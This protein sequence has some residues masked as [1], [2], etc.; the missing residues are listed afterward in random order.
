MPHHQ[1]L[2]TYLD[3]TLPQHCFTAFHF[4]IYLS[5]FYSFWFFCNFIFRL[6]KKY[7]KIKQAFFL[8]PCWTY[9]WF[10]F[11]TSLLMSCSAIFFSFAWVCL[12]TT[13]VTK[14][15][16]A[17]HECKMKPTK[18]TS[19]W[20]FKKG[21]I[22]FFLTSWCNKH[23]SS[24]QARHMNPSMVLWCVAEWECRTFRLLK[25]SLL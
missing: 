24:R 21:I 25:N 19:C 17:R 9:I 14:L 2:S 5:A 23:N 3:L 16:R 1:P 13:S 7:A 10:V 18:S 12:F 15:R 4:K 11:T 8:R 20:R 6:F 22:Y